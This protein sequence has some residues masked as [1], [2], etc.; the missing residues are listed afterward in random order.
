VVLLNVILFAYSR[1]IIRGRKIRV[2]AVAGMKV[3]GL[4]ADN[5]MR[6]RDER[7]EDQAKYKDLP[8]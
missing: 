1:G 4:I 7:I 2:E 3:E 5:D 8:D 6:Q